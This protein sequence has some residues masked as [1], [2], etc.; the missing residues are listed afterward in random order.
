MSHF[1]V[2]VKIPKETLAKC[3]QNIERAIE[4]ALAPYEDG[5]D[6][7][8]P[9]ILSF[10]DIE[11]EYELKYQTEQ[12]TWYR[13]DNKLLC[14]WDQ[15]FFN[16]NWRLRNDEQPQYLIPEGTEAITLK[17]TERF[18]TF[19][20]YMKQW[21]QYNSRDEQTERYG[22][23]YNPQAKWD[24]WEVG[25]RW[26]GKL[27]SKPE[28]VDAQR[29]GFDIIDSDELDIDYMNKDAKA[30]AAEQ[31]RAIQAYK[32]LQQLKRSDDPRAQRD[33]PLN[34]QQLEDLRTQ[35]REK[36]QLP[37]KEDKN[38]IDDFYLE[39]WI[40]DHGLGQIQIEDNGKRW[41]KTEEIDQQTFV[42]RFQSSF[43]F[44][45]YAVL[46]EHRK[47][48]EAGKMKMFGFSDG[49]P[50]VRQKWYNTFRERFLDQTAT[51]TTLVMV[52]CHI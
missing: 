32:E 1:S 38:S 25:G 48:Q 33:V 46:D 37:L 12:H 14:E 11:D 34:R 36:H 44:H 51:G 28:D 3:D 26:S 2:L 5:T 22:Y 4:N 16:P 18:E 20:Q 17:M 13:V 42:D 52:D 23:W 9:E 35:L 8:P 6:N 50:E 39:L 24:G 30:L 47:W 31:W 43:Q 40:T 21:H 41:L 45:T 19:E 49:T 10:K 7:L 15:Q 27:Y 29:E